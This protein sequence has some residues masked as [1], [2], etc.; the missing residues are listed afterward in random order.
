MNISEIENGQLDN[1]TRLRVLFPLKAPPVVHGSGSM[2][3]TIHRNYRVSE[4]G[5]LILGYAGL[6]FQ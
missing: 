3:V 6:G 5:P 1:S 4:D 2:Q